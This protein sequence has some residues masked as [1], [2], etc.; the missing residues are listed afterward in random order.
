MSPA[1]EV[2]LK[3][4]ALSF[5]QLLRLAQTELSGPIDLRAW[6]LKEGLTP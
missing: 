5:S 2:T 3:L 4:Y 6:L 1:P